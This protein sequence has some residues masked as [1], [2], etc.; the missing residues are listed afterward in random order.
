VSRVLLMIKSLDP[1]GAQRLLVDGLKCAGGHFDYEVAYVLGGRDALV[2]ELEAMGTPVICLD[3]A[4]RLREHVRANAIDLVHVHSPL[5][6]VQARLALPRKIPLVYTEHSPWRAYHPLTRWANRLTYARNDHVFAVAEAV[7]RSIRLAPLQKTPPIETLYHGLV[8][9]PTAG[10]T[11]RL[12]REL[13]I[14]ADAPLVCTVA[15]FR[16][17]KGH[18]LLIRAAKEVHRALPDT[19]FVL[20]GE[21]SEEPKVRSEANG[22]AIFAGRRSD[23]AQVVGECDAFVLPSLCEGLPIALLE[24][25]AQ[26]RPVVVTDAGGMPEV[27]RDGQDGVV[28]PAGDAPALA[29]AV[30]EV[31][32]NPGRLG[33]AAA[34][35]AASFDLRRAV[36]RIEQV[37]EQLLRSR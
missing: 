5:P 28:V 1:G 4:S 14:P 23:A 24:A 27:V 16:P 22:S 26:R 31:L 7:R 32:Q 36:T 30:I 21:G 11:G 29:R 17:E 12:R 10:P 6:A 13:N 35:R 18:R 9:P 37:Y 25:M 19:R 3:G 33:A 34:Q 8:G 20:I 15:E 2:P